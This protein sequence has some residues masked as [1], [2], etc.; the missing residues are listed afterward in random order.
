MGRLLISA[1]LA[2]SLALALAGA[3]AADRP[4]A[5]LLSET[6]F[7]EVD[8]CTGQV[9]DVTIDATFYVHEHGAVT[10]ARG[11]RTLSTTAGY[12]GR[13]TSSYVLNGNVELFRFTDV[14]ADDL[15]NRIRASGVFLFDVRS[16]VVRLDTFVLTCVG[17]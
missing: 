13:G 9:H 3:A 14:L 8:P 4:T 5:F 15:G 11:A 12:A 1:V 16:G 7:D 6:V 10:A 2:A 17:S